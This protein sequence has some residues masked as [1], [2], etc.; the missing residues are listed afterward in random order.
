[1]KIKSNLFEFEGSPIELLILIIGLNNYKM[2]CC[3]TNSN[4]LY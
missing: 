1:M 3:T 2:P 4:R